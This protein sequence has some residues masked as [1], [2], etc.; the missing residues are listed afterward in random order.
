[1]HTQKLTQE[2]SKNLNL[3]SKDKI[4]TL[5]ETSNLQFAFI[6]VEVTHYD[7]LLSEWLS[8]VSAKQS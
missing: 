2:T 7:Q 5:K 6:T 3:S 8:L 4:Q 1:M